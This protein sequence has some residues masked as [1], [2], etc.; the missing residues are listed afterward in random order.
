[1][2]QFR[3]TPKMGNGVNTG[4]DIKGSNVKNRGTSDDIVL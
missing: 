3:A 1:M 4:A 2:Y